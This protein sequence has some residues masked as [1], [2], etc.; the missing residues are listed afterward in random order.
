MN[1]YRNV[2]VAVIVLAL[3]Q[4]CNG[5]GRI[6][7]SGNTSKPQNQQQANTDVNYP[8]WAKAFIKALPDWE[9]I[10]CD[11]KPMVK[12]GTYYGYRLVLRQGRKEYIPTSQGQR[13][14]VQ[15]ESN[16]FVMKYTHIDLVL[17]NKLESLPAKIIDEIPWLQLEQEQ[18][19]KPVYMGTGLNYKWFVN[20]TLYHQEDIRKKLSLEGGD[21]RLQLL[22]DGLFVKDKGGWTANSSEYLVGAFGDKA[23]EYIKKAVEVNKDKDPGAAIS[24]LH[25]IQSEQSTELLKSYYNSKDTRIS[26]AAAGSLVHEPL[27]I[28][29]RQEYMKML[30]RQQYINAIGN[31]CL[32]YDWKDAIPIFERICS[33]P[34]SWR[35]YYAA[36]IY[37]RSLEGRPVSEELIKAQGIIENYDY[38]TKKNDSN[39]INTA[40]QII[41]ESSDKEAAAVVAF[42]LVA[43]I[44]K[45]TSTNIS[46]IGWDILRQLP[47]EERKSLYK[48]VT[49]IF[50][51]ENFIVWNLKDIQ[52]QFQEI[53]NE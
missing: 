27:R 12:V 29:A 36:Y 37:K 26:D 24:A 25:W 52:K 15:R 42:D 43:Y 4:I 18:F 28:S 17:F 9:I 46:K 48:K 33:E 41:L 51:S 16:Q 34:N 3:I 19:T 53:L 47:V 11:E 38:S 7:E 50:D 39:T 1:R 32:K 2:F 8:V 31:A 10:Q 23:I 44:T 5:Q 20:T 6:A 14:A 35:N 49:H 30:A 40:K 21:D 22:T 13:A 45:G